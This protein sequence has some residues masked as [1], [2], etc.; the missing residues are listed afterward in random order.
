MA[1]C[2]PHCRMTRYL[3]PAFE[4]T[5]QEERLGVSVGETVA[6]LRQECTTILRG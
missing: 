1:C 4:P 6:T 3:L 5:E 2:R